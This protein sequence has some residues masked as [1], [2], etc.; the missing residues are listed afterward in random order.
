MELL[1]PA[2]AAIVAGYDHPV[3]GEYAAITRNR[4]GKGEVTYVGFMPSDALIEKLLA[5][6]VDR[7]GV[8]RPGADLDFPIVV[9]GG[10]N[11]RGRAILYLLNYSAASRT[12]VYPFGAG[13]D[14]LSG[15]PVNPS[16]R[17]NLG[18]WGV[19]IIEESPAR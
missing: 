17:I 15:K 18:H 3:W 8:S 5:E 2:T 7:A 4:Y 16:D 13:T 9:R 6:A 1:Q 14:L 10:V 19:A 11:G 12:V